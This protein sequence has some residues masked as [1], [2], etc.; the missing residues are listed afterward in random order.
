M[1]LGVNLHVASPEGYHLPTAAV[2]RATSLARG[3]PTLQ[4]Q[5]QLLGH[6][7]ARGHQ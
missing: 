2:Q 1:M 6:F 3:Q 7:A 5:R 4:A